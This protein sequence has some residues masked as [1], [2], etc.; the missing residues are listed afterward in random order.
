MST[1]TGMLHVIGVGPGDPELLTLKAARVIA[2]CTIIAYF[3]KR[4]EHGHA[5]RTAAGMIRPGT[6][7]VRLEYPFTTEVVVSDPDYRA[8]IDAFYAD[9]AARLAALLDS[10][11]D[12]GLLCQ[13]DPLFYGSCL[14][15]I[16]R[17]GAPRVSVIPGV[18]GMSGCWTAGGLAMT[19]GDDV[20]T[21]LPATLEQDVLT[22]RL[23][24]TDAAVIMKLGR[25]LLKVRAALES[26]DRLG[27]AIYV[28]H[29]TMPMQRVVPLIEVRE[30]AAPYFALV[31]VPGRQ[32]W[33]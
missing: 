5:R 6:E 13:G 3:A 17:L 25:N 11:A 8:R 31:L 14:A 27:R 20:L 33:R 22:A 24:S 10:G 23:R 21:V 7:E 19:H 28:E 30:T 9:C 18:S 4:G 29:G 16:D 15:L 32:R 1:Q 2:A 12:I 26:S